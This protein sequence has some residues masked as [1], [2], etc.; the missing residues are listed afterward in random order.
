MANLAEKRLRTRIIQGFECFIRISTGAWYEEVKTD[1]AQ[2]S[3]NTCK[4]IY[5]KSTH[6]K[7]T[8][9]I[10]IKTTHLSSFLS[11]TPRVNS[12]QFST[13]LKK[14]YVKPRK[15]SQSVCGCVLTHAKRLS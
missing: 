6:S 11:V 3:S 2:S 13:I 1:S 15:N 9:R 14:F 10:L 7:L 8:L 5:Q 4:I 12:Q